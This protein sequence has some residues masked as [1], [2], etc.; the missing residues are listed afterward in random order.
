MLAFVVYLLINQLFPV[1][2]RPESVSTVAPL[3][4]HLPDNSFPSGHAIFTGASVLAVGAFIS[5]GLGV[6]FAMLGGM[7]CLARIIAGVHYPLD[8]IAG[9]ILGLLLGSFMTWILIIYRRH[10]TVKALVTAPIRIAS[11]FKL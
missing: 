1:R 10:P 2:P 3:I 4:A 5:P 9:L 11:Y 6:L 7:M 8:I